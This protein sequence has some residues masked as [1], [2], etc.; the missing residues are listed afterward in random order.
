MRRRRRYLS[1]ERCY[2]RLLMDWGKWRVVGFPW[3]GVFKLLKVK[4]RA[5]R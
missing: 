5:A 2:Y 1:I 3:T 4:A